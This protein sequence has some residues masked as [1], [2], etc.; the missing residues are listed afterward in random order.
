MESVSSII[1]T[2]GIVIAYLILVIFG[3]GICS[4][5]YWRIRDWFKKP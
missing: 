1:E 4:D 3:Y 5:A 2:I